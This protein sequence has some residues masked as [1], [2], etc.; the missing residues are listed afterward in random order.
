MIDVPDFRLISEVDPVARQQE[1]SVATWNINGNAQLGQRGAERRTHIAEQIYGLFDQRSDLIAIGLQ[2]VAN[3]VPAGR[4]VTDILEVMGFYVAVSD[5]TEYPRS[6]KIPPLSLA[7]VTKEEPVGILQTS[8]DENYSR[9]GYRHIARV[10]EVEIDF[11]NPRLRGEEPDIR[12][13]VVTFG[14]SHRLH[15]HLTGLSHIAKQTKWF[16]GL[17]SSPERAEQHAIGLDANTS[18][19]RGIMTDHG[20]KKHSTTGGKLNPTW[21]MKGFPLVRRNIDHTVSSPDL[22]PVASEVLNRKPSDHGLFLTR[23]RRVPSQS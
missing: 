3:T 8:M 18:R 14:T 16:R 19:L 22:L 9:I 2:E 11:A 1:F 4:S 10:L 20:A 15:P 21:H 5:P 13:D 12:P 23:L 7:I 6:G 17:M